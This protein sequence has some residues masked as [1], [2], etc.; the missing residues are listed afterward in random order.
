MY[1]LRQADQN[2]EK[3]N[4]KGGKVI[5]LQA[6]T[7]N[8]KDNSTDAGFQFTFFCDICNDGHRSSFIESATYKKKKGT[9]LLSQGAGLVGGLLGGKAR[10][11]GYS[12][13]RGGS[14]LSERFQG[15]PPEWH[16]EREK[17]FERT[18]NEAMQHFSRCPHCNK[19]L[20]SHCRNED[21]GLCVS[22]APRQEVYV[23][24]AKADAMKRNIDD[25]GKD[26]SV[27]AGKIESKTTIC[28]SCGKPAGTGKFCNN[29]GASMDL[30]ECPQ[31][32][33]KNAQTVR[34]CNNCGQNMQQ[35]AAVSGQ[36]SACGFENASGTKFCGDCGNKL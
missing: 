35:A 25:A 29:C 8:Y 14:I 9:R 23:A 21:E 2:S 27:W 3:T 19:Y 22:C 24:R 31:C 26:A 1:H 7:R 12:A 18:Q 17:A 28:T 20:C 13:E 6:F 16:K 4:F 36:C 30:K 32:Q 5:M 33:A 15:Q 34:F 10:D 11:I